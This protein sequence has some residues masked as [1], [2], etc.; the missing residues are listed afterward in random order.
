MPMTTKLDR[1]LFYLEI[2]H[3]S[4]VALKSSGLHDKVE[5]ISSL[6]QC[7]W[8]P[9]LKEGSFSLMRFCP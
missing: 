6:P 9:N 8:S 7:L 3:I 2:L 5:L 4:Q 1:L